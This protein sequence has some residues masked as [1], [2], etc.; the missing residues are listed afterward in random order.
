MTVLEITMGISEMLKP[1]LKE[2]CDCIALKVL[3]VNTGKARIGFELKDGAT[4]EDLRSLN[5]NG[6]SLDFPSSVQQLPQQMPQQMPQQPGQQMPQQPAIPRVESEYSQMQGVQT[7]GLGQPVQTL[8]GPTANASQTAPQMQ[9][10]AQTQPTQGAFQAPSQQ[11]PVAAGLNPQ[12]PRAPQPPQGMGQPPTQYQ[13][14]Q[15]AYQSQQPPQYQ[16]PTQQWQ[17][18]APS[19]P[20]PYGYQPQPNQP[21][22]QPNQPYGQPQ[23]QQWQ[24]PMGPLPCVMSLQE[25]QGLLDQAQNVPDI[26]PSR[27]L[28]RQEAAEIERYRL[29]KAAYVV[30][31]AGQLYIDDIQVTIRPDVAANLSSVPL[32]RLKKSGQLF[33]AFANGLLKFVSVEEAKVRAE[34]AEVNSA[35]EGQGGLPVFHDK[36]QAAYMG[37][38]IS[39]SPGGGVVSADGPPPGMYP[40][41]Y[42]GAAYNPS[43][44]PN[45][46]GAYSPG[47]YAQPEMPPGAFPAPG[48]PQG[49]P[50]QGY[51]PQGY[52]GAPQGYLGQPNVM[53]QDVYESGGDEQSAMINATGHG[54]PM[55]GQ[56]MPYGQGYDPPSVA[57]QASMQNRMGWGGSQTWK[58]ANRLD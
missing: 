26:D 41:A 22:G 2:N 1:L 52:P 40:G 44:Y 10:T 12:P 7:T 18:Q 14:P 37:A 47:A 31:N 46:P 15:Q 23:Q 27:R 8:F 32:A 49:Y 56:Q 13:Q 25:L 58:P 39:G 35:I 45:Q 20:P 5:L 34:G 57:M 38:F 4:V 11:P 33:G 53:V 9:R 19:Q 36:D 21:Y 3:D 29:P 51:P 50:P 43:A 6:L 17:P 55:P 30:S 42:N 16:Q 28:T 54:S 48:V 24:Q